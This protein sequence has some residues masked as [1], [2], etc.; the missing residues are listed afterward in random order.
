MKKNSILLIIVVAFLGMSGYFL[1]NNYINPLTKRLGNEI[2]KNLFLLQHDYAYMVTAQTIDG[3]TSIYL[4][5]NAGNEFDIWEPGNTGNRLYATALMLDSTG[6]C[7]TSRYAAEPW[8]NNQDIASLK[9]MFSRETGIDEKDIEVTGRT[10]RMTMKPAILVGKGNTTEI[11]CVRYHNGSSQA[12]ETAFIG[13]LEDR[14]PLPFKRLDLGA[15]YPQY[16]E[17]SSELYALSIALQDYSANLP[18]L[19]EVKK[20]TSGG[21]DHFGTLLEAPGFRLAE[22]SPVYDRKMNLVGVYTSASGAP[23]KNYI[24]SFIRSS[25]PPVIIPQ[26]VLTDLTKSIMESEEVE[27]ALQE[28][29]KSVDR[30][31][32]VLKQSLDHDASFPFTILEGWKVLEEIEHSMVE[33]DNSG[34]EGAMLGKTTADFSFNQQQGQVRIKM[35]TSHPVQI[36]LMRRTDNGYEEDRVFT[37]SSTGTFNL[38]WLDGQYYL[39]VSHAPASIFRIVFEKKT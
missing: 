27:R 16:R 34:S 12:P 9:K 26:E 5:K 36:A 11:E 22:G 19:V 29:E 14:G 25:I 8:R 13:R 20:I 35:E 2:E 32:Y 15:N 18:L 3:A 23:Q 38:S 39:S 21:D 37:A 4:V 24:S 17:K 30:A 33:F 28:S 1:Y 31:E 10:I 7:I 6:V